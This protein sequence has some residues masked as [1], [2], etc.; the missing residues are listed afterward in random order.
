MGLIIVK[1][2]FKLYASLTQY[3]PPEAERNMVDVEIEDTCTVHAVFERYQVPRK[4]VQLVVIN[5]VYVLP[6]LR[7]EAIFK[8]D[9]VLAVWPPVA[10]G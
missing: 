2:T 7:D 9:D 1:I 6:E 10:G 8:A 4:S 3:L 5:G